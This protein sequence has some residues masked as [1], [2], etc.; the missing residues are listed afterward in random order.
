MKKNKIIIVIL[1]SIFFIIFVSSLYII[2]RDFLECKENSDLTEELIENTF[3]SDED[4]K[5]ETINWQYLNE[6][7][8]DIVGWIEIKN[9]NI[10]YPILRDNNLYYL[11]H[12]YDKKYN[13][14]GSIFTTDIH[15]FK[16]ETIIYGH[17]M[18][19][20]TMFSEIGKYL[21]KNFLNNHLS[22]K[23][24]TP[25]ITYEAN[26]FS[27][28]SIGINEEKI[29]IKNLDFDSRIEYYKKASKY[30]LEYN[31][32]IN[33]IVKLSTCSYINAKV[34]PTDQRYYIIAAISPICD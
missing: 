2:I 22:F 10:S 12:S 30:K 15:P 29:N 11:R 33:K 8:S 31:D 21:D 27:V 26:V 24:Y 3:S 14:N 5:E 34:S 7:N 6:I 28:Y 23:I 13:M 17:N 18:K 20:G 19:N 9:T 32:E 25:S 16:E 4:T 1:I